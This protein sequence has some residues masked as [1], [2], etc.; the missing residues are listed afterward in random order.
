[1]IQKLIQINQGKADKTTLPEELAHHLT[2]TLKDSILVTR[3]INLVNKLGVREILGDEFDRYNIAYKGDKMLLAHEALGKLISK[4]IVSKFEQP[5]ELKSETGNKLWETIKRL[6]DKFISLF[7]PNANIMNSLQKDVDSLAD[8]VLNGEKVEGKSFEGEMYQLGKNFKPSKDI[9]KQYRYFKTIITQNKIKIA[10]Y[11]KEMLRN[12]NADK[13]ELTKKIEVLKKEILDINKALL[14]LEASGNKQL[15]TELSHVILEKS[16]EYLRTLLNSTE[17][18]IADNSINYLKE[19][20]DNFANFGPTSQ[21]ALEIRKNFLEPVIL[22]YALQITSAVRGEEITE[23]KY[24]EQTKDIFSGTKNVGTLT[25]IADLLGSTIG[26]LIKKAQHY[27]ALRNNSAYKLVNKQVKALEAYSNSVGVSHKDMYK[28]FIQ[29]H[30]GT[31]VLTR[32]YSPAFYERLDKSFENKDSGKE[33]RRKFATWD[34]VNEKF[35]PL[36]LKEYSNSNFVKIQNTKELK[37]FYNFFKETISDIN[38][39]LPVSLNDNFIPNIAE[40]TLMDIFKSDNTLMGKLKDGIQN[41]TQIYDVKDNANGYVFDESLNKDAVPLKYIAKIAADKKSS[42]LGSSLLQFMYFANSYEEMTEVLP[43]TKL[44]L[45]EIENKKYIKNTNSNTISGS[46]TNVYKMAEKFIEMQVLGKLKLEEAWGGIQYGKIIDF[47]LK[48][49]SLLRIGLNP[50]NAATN[51][52]VGRLGNLI[53]AS[54]GR[55]FNNKELFKA[56]GIFFKEVNFENSKMYALI[57]LLNPLMDLEDYENLEKIGIAYTLT[58]KYKEKVKNSMYYLQKSGEKYLQTTTM[59]ASLMHDK[60]T[61]LDGKTT[62]S[63]YEAFDEKGE[64]KTAEFGELTQDR[65][66]KMSNKIQ[67]INKSIHGRY[68]AK[69]AAILNQYVLFRVFSQFKKWMPAAFESRF[70]SKRFDVNLQMDVEGRY[71]TYLKMFKTMHLQLTYDADAM[72]KNGWTEL[73]VYNMRKN[74]AE[75]AIILALSIIGFGLSEAGDDDDDLKKKGWYK[76]AMGQLDRIS[77]DLTYFYNPMDMNRTIGNGAPL[78]KTISDFGKVI[79]AIPHIFGMQGKDDFYRS[80]PKKG[81]NKFW[82]NASRVTIGVKPFADTYSMLFGDNSYQAP[83]K[84]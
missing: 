32:E 12:P 83:V 53:E 81:E 46:E 74:M 52:A 39:K 26:T 27:I 31:T 63:L 20:I 4:A 24:E 80:G 21:E 64:W 38:D 1:M 58:E 77:G 62:V 54:G 19:S 69:D 47:G 67:T 33:E 44:L 59:M 23:E 10:K 34:D 82:A 66:F 78:F 11:D 41:I 76:F 3:A 55:H 75:L 35:I 50:F 25:N 73:D 15:F 16:K 40:Q 29:E 84:R 48:Y 18:I 71:H 7:T 79:T 70:E 42:D 37:Q 49:T 45:S 8:M 51:V 72:Q 65:I 2:L 14:E 30:R 17:P 68:S 5:N 13:K 57:K 43:Q 61:S 6:V 36:N 22:K 9:E 28:V 60:I 56:E